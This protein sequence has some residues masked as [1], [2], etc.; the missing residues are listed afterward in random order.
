MKVTLS[1]LLVRRKEL[2]A[3]HD[4]FN[5]LTKQNNIFEPRVQRRVVSDQQ[6]I[7][8]IDAIIPKTTREAVEREA[9]YYSRLWR[10]VDGLI[11]QLN[12]T[13]NVVVPA[14][15]MKEFVTDQ[16]PPEGDI[17][18][19]L[20]ALLGR[21]KALQLKVT[22]VFNNIDLAGFVSQVSARKKMSEGI[23][24]L[25]NQEKMP[26]HALVRKP[27][28]YLKAFKECEA[29]VARTNAKTEVDIKDELF[30]DFA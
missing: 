6:G 1:E 30:E 2:K 3:R 13:T 25:L 10:L 23:E 5:K 16:T 9:D 26:A 22:E 17:T 18:E 20:A 28:F 4:L 19:T 12:H 11:Q 27:L 29:A 7:E 21:R 15:V 14:F 8:Q 24:D